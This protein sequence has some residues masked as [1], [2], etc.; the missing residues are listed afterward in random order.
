MK[1]EEVKDKIIELGVWFFVLGFA[2][3]LLAM[4][5]LFLSTQ[6]LICN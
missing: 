5:I 4:K 2:T 3:A 6:S 1:L